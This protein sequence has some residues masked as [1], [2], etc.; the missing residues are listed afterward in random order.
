MKVSGKKIE[1]L[2]VMKSISRKEI[3]EISNTSESYIGKIERGESQPTVPVAYSICSALGVTI[4]EI[5]VVEK[6]RYER[7]KVI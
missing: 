6:E 4:D 7:K 1:I 5:L 2:R 3:A